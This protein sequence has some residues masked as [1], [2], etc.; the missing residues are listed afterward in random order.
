[1]GNT[2]RADDRTAKWLRWIAR[3][4]GTSA[5][6]LFLFVAVVSA[7]FDPEPWTLEGA[8]LAGLV[9]VAAVGVALAW[10]REGT[11]GTVVTAAGIALSI[12]AYVSAGHNKWFA[13]LVAGGPFLASGALFLACWWR[14][15]ASHHV[16]K[17]PPAAP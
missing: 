8:V 17:R 11:G 15:A 5:S 12:F 2:K 9:L 7:F 6:A 4:V 16:Q 3:A 13:V 1:M 10:W 14:A